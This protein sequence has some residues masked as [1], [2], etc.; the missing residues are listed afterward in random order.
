MTH[1]YCPESHSSIQR[2]DFLQLF[3]KVYNLNSKG[4]KE[5]KEESKL[6]KCKILLW[7][8]C[9]AFLIAQM[10]WKTPSLF[11]FPGSPLSSPLLHHS[12]HCLNP[13]SFPLLQ[14]PYFSLPFS[15]LMLLQEHHPTS[16][17]SGKTL[18]PIQDLQSIQYS[19]VAKTSVIIN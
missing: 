3:W 8:F 19:L 13:V 15:W 6:L 16:S 7:R 14:S 2:A 9:L 10:C 1:L 17:K 18:G 4:S 11:C 12:S 5:G